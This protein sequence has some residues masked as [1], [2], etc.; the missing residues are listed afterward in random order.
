[1]TKPNPPRAACPICG[2]PASPDNRPF[3]T[4]RCAD[5][6]L[7]RWLGGAYRIPIDDPEADVEAVEVASPSPPARD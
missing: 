4:K 1:M 7:S 5:V 2:R 3:C 6:D